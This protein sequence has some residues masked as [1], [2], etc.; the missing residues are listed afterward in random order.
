MFVVTSDHGEE[1][2]EHKS[3]GHG[4]SVYQELLHVPLIY[5]LPGVV[6][7]GKRIDEAVG[8]LDIT[9]TVLTAM[10]VPIPEAVEGVDRMGHLMG[11]VPAGPA[12]SFSD[13]LDDRRVIQA[14]RWKLILNGV[15]PTFFDLQSD[16]LEQKELAVTDHSIARRY[17]RILLGQFLATR[18][19]GDWLA[20]DPKGK[21]VSFGTHAAEIDD[22][23]RKGLKALG[24]AN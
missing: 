13:F 14:G 8:T 2:Y 16:P 10:G 20:A 11:A 12:V 15:N 17:C 1:F 9:P 18:D 3:W 22:T 19:R 5:R 23:T 4:H 6:P 7:A 21:S 24:Y